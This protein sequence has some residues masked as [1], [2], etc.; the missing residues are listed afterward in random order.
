MTAKS[1]PPIRSIGDIARELGIAAWDKLNGKQ[2]AR[3]LELAGQA[4][5]TELQIQKIIEL[6]KAFAPIAASVFQAVQTVG[7]KAS[8]GQQNLIQNHSTAT[9]TALDTLKALLKETLDENNKVKLAQMIT[10]LSK[11]ELVGIERINR[12]NNRFWAIFSSAAAALVTV[13]LLAARKAR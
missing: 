9:L 1:N 6:S 12:S 3:I 5:I 8:G 4:K 13:G 7:E 10:D 11:E 2:V